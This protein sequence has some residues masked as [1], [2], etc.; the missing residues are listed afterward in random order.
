MASGKGGVGKSTVSVNL[1]VRQA[2]AP[3]IVE[4]VA[5]VLRDTGLPA[6]LLQLER[7]PALARGELNIV[8]ATTLEEYRRKVAETGYLSNGDLD[9]L[10]GLATAAGCRGSTASP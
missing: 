6:D 1:A 10:T 4:E 9:R 7:R 5:R 3:G 2:N 8:G